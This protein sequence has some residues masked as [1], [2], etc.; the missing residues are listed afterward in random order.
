MVQKIEIA[1]ISGNETTKGDEKLVKASI[2]FQLSLLCLVFVVI[3]SIL[4]YLHFLQK[5]YQRQEKGMGF[6]I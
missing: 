2:N 5:A 3:S 4:K 1:V 6:D